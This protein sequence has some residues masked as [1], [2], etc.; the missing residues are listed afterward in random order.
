MGVCATIST[1]FCL[2]AYCVCSC[3][4]FLDTY[5][6]T[7][8]AGLISNYGEFAIIKIWIIHLFPNAYVF[9][10]ITIA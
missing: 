1:G 7:I 6:E 9:K 10:C 2:Y 8:E 4:K 5:F 3:H